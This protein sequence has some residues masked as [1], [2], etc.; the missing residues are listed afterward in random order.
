MKP[1]LD[2]AILGAGCAGLSLA[3]ALANARVPGRIGLLEPRT[4]YTRDRTWCFWNTEEH[5]FSSTISHSW[6]S[7]RVS[8]GTREALQQSRRY[9]YCHI[10][11]DDF[12]RIAAGRVEREPAQ[13][14]C[15]GVTVHSVGP[16]TSGLT[17]I[18]TNKGRQLAKVVFDSRPLRTGTHPPALLQR[19]LGW[20]VQTEEPCFQPETVELMRFL[21]SGTPGRL[22]FLY[23]LPFSST[24]ALVEMTYLDDPRLPEPP[25]NADL[26]NWLAERTS[27]YQVLYAE[28]GTLPMDTFL[29]LTQQ[30]GVH[31]I[32]TAGGR[33]KPSSGYGFLRIQRHS[34][35]IAEA[36]LQGRPL[37]QTAEPRLYR[38]MDVFFL[39]ALQSSPAAAI[40]L[41]LSM[42][43]HSR[44]DELV[45]FLG[46]SSD[47]GETLRVALTLPKLPMLRALLPAGLPARTGALRLR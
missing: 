17:A 33:L 18:E 16:H 5:P 43:S 6:N 9:R 27:R 34:L 25:A 14:L 41:F 20:H 7:W 3:T 22:R 24:E 26:Q 28:H 42:F 1:D 11:G 2:I 45:R 29:P 44:P 21:P 46:E 4:A 35:A 23:L 36:L 31:A 39:R 30:P 32:G 37:P 38:W 15:H 13:E 19:F 8:H 12:Y 47:P 10:A 40:E